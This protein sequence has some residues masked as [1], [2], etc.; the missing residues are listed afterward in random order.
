[1][2]YE[3]VTP[4]LENRPKCSLVID[5]GS[6]FLEET[7]PRRAPDSLELMKSLQSFYGSFNVFTKNLNRF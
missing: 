4:K 7:F 2:E 6:Q 1:M 5:G 3:L